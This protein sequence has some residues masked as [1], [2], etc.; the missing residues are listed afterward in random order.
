MVR[1][2]GPVVNFHSFLEELDEK[3][4]SSDEANV[5]TVGVHEVV[6]EWVDVETEAFAWLGAN[7]LV[8]AETEVVDD[9]HLSHDVGNVRGSVGQT[10]NIQMHLESVVV[11]VIDEGT[12]LSLVAVVLR[13][14]WPGEATLA[15]GVGLVGDEDFVVSVLSEP[16]G[17]FR[18]V[19]LHIGRKIS[20]DGNWLARGNLD[21][22]V[23]VTPDISS[24][25]FTESTG[26][27]VVDVVTSSLSV[28][29]VG[30]AVGLG[31]GQHRAACKCKNSSDL[32]KHVS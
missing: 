31:R 24:D 19:G 3:V 27:I 20:S 29:V 8:H 10:A 28:P 12:F 15:E 16:L 9:P 22:L 23:F 2:L 4:L 6:V 7:A 18:V 30:V 1:S 21:I 17:E 32:G 13:G 26:W 11:P 5:G 25:S 14:V